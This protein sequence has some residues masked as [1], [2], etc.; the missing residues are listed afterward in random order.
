MRIWHIN[1]HQVNCY[2]T[3]SY[4]MFCVLWYDVLQ[5]M[6]CVKCVQYMFPFQINGLIISFE[7][8]SALYLSHLC[9]CSDTFTQIRIDVTNFG[10]K[11]SPNFLIEHSLCEYCIYSSLNSSLS[12][13]QSVVQFCQDESH[14]FHST[15]VVRCGERKYLQHYYRQLPINPS[16]TDEILSVERLCFIKN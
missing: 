16:I 4:V 3:L 10:Y 12:I 8:S 13:I 6:R 11:R 7:W 9:T 14:H 5:C 2:R 1:T 15:F